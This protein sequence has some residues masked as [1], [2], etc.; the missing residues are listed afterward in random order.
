MNGIEEMIRRRAYRLWDRAGRPS[1][2]GEE[3]WLA[4]KTEIERA[5]DAGDRKLGP[6]VPRRLETRGET[7]SDWNTRR[8]DPIF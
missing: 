5:T 2:R 1:G 3:F 6:L 7:A 4:A 8:P